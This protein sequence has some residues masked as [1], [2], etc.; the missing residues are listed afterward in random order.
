MAYSDNSHW[1]DTMLNFQIWIATLSADFLLNFFNEHCTLIFGG[2][3][4]KN[5]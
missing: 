5:H 1:M 2:P 3:L 4:A